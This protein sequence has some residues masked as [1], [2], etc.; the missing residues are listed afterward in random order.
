MEVLELGSAVSAE[1]WRPDAPRARACSQ[2]EALRGTGLLLLRLLIWH[3]EPSHAGGV[4]ILTSQSA[5][6]MAFKGI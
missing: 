5:S 4:I 1:H 2:E 3:S 6:G